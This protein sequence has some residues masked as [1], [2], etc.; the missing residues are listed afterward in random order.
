MRGR[1]KGTQQCKVFK[2]SA[3]AQGKGLRLLRGLAKEK[4]KKREVNE[5]E[6]K[7]VH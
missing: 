7:F 5:I 6:G 3:G 1:V 4:S 2:S